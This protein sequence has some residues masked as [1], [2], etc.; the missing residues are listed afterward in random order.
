MFDLTQDRL[1]YT[2]R[3][4]ARR[5]PD[6]DNMQSM[7][8]V[9]RHYGRWAGLHKPHR[10]AQFLAQIMHENGE[11]RYD[12]ELWGPT[13][14]QKKYDTMTGLGNTPERDGDGYL[15]RGRGSIQ[16]TGRWNYREFTKW[17][18]KL[19]PNAPDFE[20]H[21]DM[22]N[23]DPWEGLVAIWYWM[24]RNL[25]TMAD[26]GDNVAITRRIN[27]GTNG[28]SDRLALYSRLALVLLGYKPDEI[29]EFQED[30]ASEHGLKV[31][32]ISGP[33]TRA[34]LHVELKELGTASEISK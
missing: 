31:D 33:M 10:L 20:K 23:K 21:P 34:A 27:G 24:T 19:D 26:A 5:R 29:R 18:R 13:P 2:I 11:F 17:V 6:P 25:N 3:A 9:L 28:L 32:G 14:Q 1:S 16:I 22:V 7:I 8:V 12:R 30:H 4:A 15:Y